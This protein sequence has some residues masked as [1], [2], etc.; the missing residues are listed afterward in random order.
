MLFS[1]GSVCFLCIHRAYLRCVCVFS[2]FLGVYLS[3]FC[4]TCLWLPLNKQSRARNEFQL[5]LV[6]VGGLLSMLLFPAINISLSFIVSLSVEDDH[7]WCCLCCGPCHPPH[8]HPH[9]DGVKGLLPSSVHSSSIN[10]P[11][12]EKANADHSIMDKIIFIKTE[13]Q[14]L[15]LTSGKKKIYETCYNYTDFL[16]NQN[17]PSCQ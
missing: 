7:N 2:K 6:L 11:N 1:S 3:L 16:A 17:C 5:K 13:G 12:K 8:H 4:S 9:T 10:W 14:V 15:Y